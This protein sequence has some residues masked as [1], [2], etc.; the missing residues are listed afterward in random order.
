MRE[1]WAGFF[2]SVENPAHVMNF[3]TAWKTRATGENIMALVIRNALVLTNDD[4]QPVIP[5][6]EILIEAARLRR[7]AKWRCWR[8]P[9][10]W[11]R[12]A[13][14]RC[15][16]DQRAPTCILP[17]ARLRAPPGEPAS[18]FVQILERI[19]VLVWRWMRKRCVS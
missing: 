14:W 13:W 12:A 17:C 7:W 3:S 8:A 6:G 19:G 16:A 9:R 11:M 15:R 1:N 10:C 4:A 5:H 2:H 18:N